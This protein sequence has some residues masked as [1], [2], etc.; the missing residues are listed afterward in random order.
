MSKIAIK[1]VLKNCL[2]FLS[3]RIPDL[4]TTLNSFQTE[5]FPNETILTALSDI[6]LVNFSLLSCVICAFVLAT[7][8]WSHG[9]LFA[10]LA[11]NILK[12]LCPK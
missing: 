1:I 4:L 5:I 6:E 11:H 3:Q 10:E 7:Q 9:K 8:S 12:I 2:G